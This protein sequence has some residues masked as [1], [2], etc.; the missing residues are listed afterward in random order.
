M[1]DK[2][3]FRQS[4]LSAVANK[5]WQASAERTTDKKAE[6]P[7]ASVSLIP[8]VDDVFKASAAEN[9]DASSTAPRPFIFGSSISDRVTVSLFACSSH[10]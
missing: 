2:P 9:G 1:T 8:A 6:K 5:V 3:L 10:S 4:A 7:A